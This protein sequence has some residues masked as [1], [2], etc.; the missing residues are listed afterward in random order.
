MADRFSLL[1]QISENIKDIKLYNFKFVEQFYN[2]IVL[3]IIHCD[4]VLLN[5]TPTNIIDLQ[6]YCCQLQYLDGIEQMLQLQKL[7]LNTN[8]INELGK[9][10]NLINLTFIDLHDNQICDITPLQTLVNLQEL[11]L[12][13]NQ[14][15][16]I[17]AVKKLTNLKILNLG[18]NNISDITTLS[19]LTELNTLYLW[20]NLVT[21]IE[22]L[23]YLTKLKIMS[24]RTSWKVPISQQF[25]NIQYISRLTNLT[26][27]F[28]SRSQVS[29]ISTLRNLTNLSVL[30]L[31]ENRIS[32]ISSIR[33]LSKITDL[34]LDQN[35]IVDIYVIK[36]L[37]KLQK[38][39]INS[40]RVVDL[41]PLRNLSNLIELFAIKNQIVHYALNLNFHTLFLEENYIQNFQST[42]AN[43]QYDLQFFPN[44]RQI[45]ESH[46]QKAI[47]QIFDIKLKLDSFLEKI[48]ELLS[49]NLLADQ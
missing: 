35:I 44:Q 47:N 28:I 25:Q 16:D 39:N 43:A 11:Y 17:S 21:E 49:R 26:D 15:E 6:I 1:S 27:L 7:D 14:I 37:T 36:Y 29:D 5:A 42:I 2:I 12:W 45:L 18:G 46:S 23:Q 8:C 13:S 9:L 38:L 19:S 4:C 33:Y 24:V 31:C 40:N 41:T 3:K 30:E 10:S 48:A 34:L 32:D 20:D 22:S